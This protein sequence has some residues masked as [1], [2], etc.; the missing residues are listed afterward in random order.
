MEGK[1]ESRIK[2]QFN[3]C[4]KFRIYPTKYQEDYFNDLINECR[5]VYNKLIDTGPFSG[6]DFTVSF[7][8]A[9]DTITC[10]IANLSTTINADIVTTVVL[11]GSPTT[12]TVTAL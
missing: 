3:N 8:Q 7:T 12:Q 4:Y 6:E 11:G 5:L 1:S 10:N 9:T 2:S